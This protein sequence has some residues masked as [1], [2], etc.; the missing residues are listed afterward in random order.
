M[1]RMD[2]HI[3]EFQLPLRL[4]IEENWLLEVCLSICLT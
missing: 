4:T 2:A 1:R 3:G